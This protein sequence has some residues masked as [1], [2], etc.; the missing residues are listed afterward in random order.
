MDQGFL[1]LT[2]IIPNRF[3]RLRL[4]T[5]GPKFIVSYLKNH[6]DY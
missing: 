4:F 1:A 5:Y 2:N 6:A 3:A